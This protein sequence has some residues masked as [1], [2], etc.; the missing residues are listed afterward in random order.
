MNKTRT[1][2][3]NSLNRQ[4]N[5][6]DGPVEPSKLFRVERIKPV[7]GNPFWEKKILKLLGLAEKVMSVIV[8]SRPLRLVYLSDQTTICVSSPSGEPSDSRRTSIMSDTNDTKLKTIQWSVEFK[9]RY[10]FFRVLPLLL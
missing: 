4:P 8:L 10:C 2:I 9:F 6:D 7:K 5:H 1:I 3:P